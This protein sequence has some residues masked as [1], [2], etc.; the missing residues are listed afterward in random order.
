M[1]FFTQIWD[2]PNVVI[3]QVMGFNTSRHGHTDWMI[4]GVP[5]RWA[6]SPKQNGMADCMYLLV[7]SNQ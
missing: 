7:Q 6:L 2:F 5:F 4:T 1:I 3:P